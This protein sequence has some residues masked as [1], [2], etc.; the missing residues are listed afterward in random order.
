MLLRP[1]FSTERHGERERKQTS[2]GT[3]SLSPGSAS[4]RGGAGA[5]SLP[6]LRVGVG[7]WGEC[8]MSRAER[9][10]GGGGWYK[11]LPHKVTAA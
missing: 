3:P 1:P 10:G 2:V 11:Q 9:G 8:Q 5:S 6:G 4:G 7:G